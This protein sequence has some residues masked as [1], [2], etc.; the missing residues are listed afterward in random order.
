[1]QFAE[2]KFMRRHERSISAIDTA[3]LVALHLAAEIL[4]GQTCKELILDDR[5]AHDEC[6]L[7]SN[8]ID[9]L[10]DPGRPGRK[11]E[12]TP[13]DT[14]SRGW[15]HLGFSM[16]SSHL[17]SA[18][19]RKRAANGHEAGLAAVGRGRSLSGHAGV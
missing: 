5:A 16:R 7:P 15:D 2:I 17:K 13:L 6:K 9:G 18:D 10:V 4:R 11:N 14:V 12:V 19:A 3:K 1:L 8:S